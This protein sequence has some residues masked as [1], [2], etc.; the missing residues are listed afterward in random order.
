[1][2]LHPVL[3][4]AFLSSAVGVPQEGDEGFEFEA[5]GQVGIE[6]RWFPE[7]PT[8]PGQLDGVQGSFFAEPEFRWSDADRTNQ[9]LFTPFLRV[10]GRDDERSHFDIREAYW[11]HV[12]EEWDVLVGM[13]RVF[14]G[15][16]ESRHLINVINQVDAVEDVDEEDFLGQPMIQAGR[17]TEYGRFDLFLMT[18]FRRRN[19]PGP[20]GRLRFGIPI[21]SDGAQYE[22]DLEEWRPDL[23]LRWSHYIGDV[24]LGLSAF[25]GTGRE[26]N[27]TLSPS[28]G[29]LIPTYF[30]INQVGVDLQ[31]TTDAWLWKFEGLLREGQGDTF[32]AAV[33]G[34]EYTIFQLNDSDADLGLL[35]EVLYDGRDDD[36]FPTIFDNDVFVGSR[37]ALNDVQSTE[38]LAG[39]VVDMQDGLGSARIEAERRLGDDW[40]LEFEAQVFFEDQA[41]NP[42]SFFENDSF[43]TLRLSWFF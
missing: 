39:V 22:E 24:D 3:V 2:T 28:G 12:G 1:M 13:N 10:D 19:F 35:A 36:V 9:F 33:G 40:K 4:A 17:E 31:Y 25:H 41:S 37:Y 42:L 15:V 26:P 7:D 38:V 29:R 43:L 18:G 11:R 20:K 34:V 30:L 5:S 32:A 16:T 21:D 8:F 27:L 6:A 23:A 14:W